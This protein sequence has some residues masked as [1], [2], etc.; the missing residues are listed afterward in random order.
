MPLFDFI[1]VLPEV[2]E[3][4]VDSTYKISRTGH[5]LFG[6]VAQVNSIGIPIA[7]F[8]LKLNNTNTNNNNNNNHQPAD[9]ATTATIDPLNSPTTSY[10][11]ATSLLLLSRK[12]LVANVSSSSLAN[13]MKLD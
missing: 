11:L 12:Q 3:Y 2:E 6:I 5:E 8:L 13:Y 7:Y 1:K 10:L 4:H 9:V